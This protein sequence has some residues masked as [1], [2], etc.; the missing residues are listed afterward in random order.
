MIPF[1]R[2]IR[3]K[4]ADDNRP[5]KYARYAIG[6]IILVVIGI[7]IALQI[8]NWNEERKLKEIEKQYLMSIKSGINLSQKELM[9]VIDDS[10]EIS[11][12]ADTLIMLLAYDEF[13]LL[14]G[15]VLDS[16]LFNAG[17]Y[18]IISMNDASIQEIYNTG[19][20]DI[21]QDERIRKILSSWTERI[22]QIRKFEG[23]SEYLSRRY[24]EYIINFID[25]SRYELRLSAVIPEKRKELLKDPLLRNH[26]GRIYGTHQHMNQIYTAEKSILDS[27]RILIDQN[28]SK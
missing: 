12:S 22:H 15:M 5:L 11:K 17:D 9:R 18:S 4:M 6:E 13:D 21:F 7:L 8:N 10:K 26:L 16:L 14:E 19:S 24:N 28:L 3:K 27:L 25:I 1:F 23:E 2:K 20:L